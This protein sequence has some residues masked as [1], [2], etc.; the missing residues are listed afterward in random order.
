MTEP[1][2]FYQKMNAA[3]RSICRYP[4][5]YLHHPHLQS[6]HFQTEMVTTLYCLSSSYPLPL[7]KMVKPTTDSK[8]IA[9][10]HHGVDI[11]KYFDNSDA[12]SYIYDTTY[13]CVHSHA[14]QICYVHILLDF[15]K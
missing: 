9:L 2:H 5:I 8:L 11:V 3:N 13:V 6:N 4:I 7:A 1:K 15:Q 14:Q 12:G 10:Q